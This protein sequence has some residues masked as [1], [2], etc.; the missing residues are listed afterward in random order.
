M[1]LQVDPRTKPAPYDNWRDNLS[2]AQARP[3]HGQGS[4]SV[5]LQCHQQWRWARDAEGAARELAESDYASDAPRA[6]ECIRMAARHNG[7]WRSVNKL[8][9]VDS[10]GKVVRAISAVRCDAGDST[11]PTWLAREAKERMSEMLPVTEACEVL[12]NTIGYATSSSIDRASSASVVAEFRS[13]QF[14]ESYG[15]VG[16]DIIVVPDSA[17]TVR[18]HLLAAFAGPVPV[19]M[20]LFG[21]V[22]LSFTPQIDISSMY[23]APT[24]ECLRLGP[25]DWIRSQVARFINGKRCRDRFTYGVF[26]GRQSEEIIV[27][28]AEIKQEVSDIDVVGPLM[29]AQINIDAALSI[30]NEAVLAGDLGAALHA[31]GLVNAYLDELRAGPLQG[32]L[33]LS[34]AAGILARINLDGLENSPVL[35][36]VHARFMT[37]LLSLPQPAIIE[38]SEWQ[39][40]EHVKISCLADI[41]ALAKWVREE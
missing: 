21:A 40:V 23:E 24:T 20:Q 12:G 27:S 38:S 3:Y 37:A 41:E 15:I 36:D 13:P 29:K 16:L 32:H 6:A 5:A 22:V 35:P 9:K 10:R 25:K 17:K 34:V 7:V 30:A 8:Q 31:Q 4:S 18:L 11:C 39:C 2:L 33:L 26:Y 14:R 19:N 1:R 28:A